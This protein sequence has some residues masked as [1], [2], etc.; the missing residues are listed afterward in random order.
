[1]NGELLIC[2]FSNKK[3]KI[4]RLASAVLQKVRAERSLGLEQQPV[5][6]MKADQFLQCE[7]EKEEDER[8]HSRWRS[9]SGL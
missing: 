6:R 4:G 8:E 5:G 7:K 2:F 1:M 3:N 9:D